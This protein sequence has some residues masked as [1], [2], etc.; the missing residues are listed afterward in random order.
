MSDPIQFNDISSE[1]WREYDFG[2]GHTV[3]IDAPQKLNVSARGGH[4]VSDAAG[5]SHYVPSGWI[6]LHWKARDGQ[7]AFVL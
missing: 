3:R 2:D 4:R 1:E 7:P 5:L 6:H